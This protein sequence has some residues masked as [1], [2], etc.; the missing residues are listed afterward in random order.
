MAGQP[1]RI[2]A[3]GAV[4]RRSFAGHYDV[5]EIQH[6]PCT[7]AQASHLPN[8]CWCCWWCCYH[9]SCGYRGHIAPR[10]PLPAVCAFCF[11]FVAIMHAKVQCFVGIFSRCCFYFI[12]LFCLCR[13]AFYCVLY[14]GVSHVCTLPLTLAN[15]CQKQ[16][17]LICQICKNVFRTC[18]L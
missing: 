4:W 1:A 3:V 14:I 12:F 16:R 5:N 10:S 18:H 17:W 9:H 2:K 6:R 11:N 7:C 8:C 15:F 13:L